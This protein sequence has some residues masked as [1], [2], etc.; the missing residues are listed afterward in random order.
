MIDWCRAARVSIRIP[1]MLAFALLGSSVLA[2]ETKTQPPG[3]LHVL[4]GDVPTV[5]LPPADHAALIASDEGRDPWLPYR[6]G[7]EVPLDIAPVGAMDLGQWIDR[8]DERLWRLRIESPGAFS[9]HLMMDSFRLVPGSRLYVYNDQHRVLGPFSDRQNR[10][11]GLFATQPLPGD[12]LTIE[13]VEPSFG[14][15]GVFNVHE[16]VHAYRD[17]FGF[18][19]GTANASGSCNINVNCPL[20]A[21]FQN[22]KRAVAMLVLG[23][24]LCTAQLLNDAA[25]DGAQY[26]LTAN[27]CAV[28][29]GAGGWSF[30]FNYEAATCTGTSGPQSDSVT[31]AT[32]LNQSNQSDYAIGTIDAP[33]PPWFN[34]YFLGWD[35]TGAPFTNSN[36]IH[37]PLGDIKKISGDNDPAAKSTAWQGTLAWQILKWDAGT[38]E[39]GS[40]GSALLDPNHRVVGQL[41]GGQAACGNSV[42][43]YFGRFDV[44]WQFGASFVLDPAQITNGTQNGLDGSLVL[45][46]D[47]QA[48]SISAPA[49]AEVGSVVSFATDIESS[50]TYPPLTFGYQ[51]RLSTDN[52]IDSSDPVIATETGTQFGPVNVDATLGFDLV[53]GNY[54]IGL[55]VDP[56]QTEANVADN[57]ILGTPL[58]L[59]PSTLPDLTAVSIA[60]PASADKGASIGVDFVVNGNAFA[61]QTY[62]VDVHLSADS[63]IT[64]LDPLLG[65]VAVPALGANTALV[66]I[67]ALMPVGNYYLGL[68]VKPAVDEGNLADNVV[69]GPL[70]EVTTPPVPPPDVKVVSIT[71]PAKGKVGKKAKIAVQLDKGNYTGKVSYTVRLSTDEIITSDDIAVGTFK[72]KKSG[73]V[74][75]QPKVPAIPAGIYF[76]GVTL[77]G[78]PDEVDFTNNSV[79][80]GGVTIKA[81][82]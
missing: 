54:F 74:K 39:P 34:V 60:G 26:F 49:T 45:S 43:D 46:V 13:Y 56:A 57:V 75:I 22:E 8:G 3:L 68:V 14:P 40:S 36:C 70:L 77:D 4:P 78:V 28:S 27:H 31:G 6:F 18:K 81:K 65:S 20:G 72:T 19:A 12:A 7:V 38:T 44:S 71:G 62:T 66:K 53:P 82:N 48:Q 55:T 1:C 35:N 9:L 67:P 10:K 21:N 33:I 51:I 61:P 37:H 50:G 73:T 25:S 30:V 79:G 5:I 64:D 32:V 76:W 24:G 23:G 15:R 29:G 69:V 80:G 42:N 59:V 16:V 2:G 58:T 47:L 52:V 63:D 41:L 11:D 17:V